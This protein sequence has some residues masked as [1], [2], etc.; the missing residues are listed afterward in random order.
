M[1][2]MTSGYLTQ[3]CHCQGKVREKQKFFKV[4]EKSGKILDIVKVSEKSGNSVFQFIVHKFSST[5]WNAF[6]FRKKEKYAVKQAQQSIW[7]FTVYAWHIHLY[8]VVVVS[9][10]H[11][12]CFLPNSF[13]LLREKQKEVENEEKNIDSLQNKRK[14]M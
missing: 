2:N 9:G 11:S 14:Q 1:I 6:S 12:E 3:G 10:F 8:V 5:L 13:F 7:H 4:R